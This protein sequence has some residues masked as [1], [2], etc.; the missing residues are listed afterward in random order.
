MPIKSYFIF[1]LL[2]IFN[3]SARADVMET[4]RQAYLAEQYSEAEKIWVKQAESGNATAQYN[5]ALQYNSGK[6]LPRNVPMSEHWLKQSAN[7]N[8]VDAYASLNNKVLQPGQGYQVNFDT[9]PEYWLKSQ[10]PG[11]YTIQIASSRNKSLIEK[12]YTEL[13]VQRLG[14]YFQYKR[15]GALWYVLVY[16]SYETVAQANSAITGLP[17]NLRK[18]TPWVRKI[19]QLQKLSTNL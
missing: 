5:L 13:G 12:Y 1:C 16:G 8:L 19:G 11:S 3:S 18:W 9:G 6:G 10:Q 15:D 7:E 2:F 4:A 17:E 14:G